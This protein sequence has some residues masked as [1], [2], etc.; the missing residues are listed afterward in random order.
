MG[1]GCMNFQSTIWQ[2][3]K[4]ISFASGRSDSSELSKGKVIRRETTAGNPDKK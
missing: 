1:T 3:S 2:R 4:V